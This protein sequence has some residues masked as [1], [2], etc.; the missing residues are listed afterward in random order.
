MIYEVV[1]VGRNKIYVMRFVD[2]VNYFYYGSL[3]FW[4][5][6]IF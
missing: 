5:K 4:V 3:G 6:E 1:L 2:F